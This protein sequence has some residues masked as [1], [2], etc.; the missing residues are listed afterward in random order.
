MD[1]L[2]QDGIIFTL[3]MPQGEHRLEKIVQEHI[4]DIFGNDA[5]S[6]GKKKIKSLA[7]IGSI[8][9][10]YVITFT[11]YPSWYVLEVE[12][13]RHSPYEHIIPQVTKFMNGIKNYQTQISLIKFFREEIAKDQILE[14]KIK[15]KIGNNEIRSF[16]TDLIRE[17]PTVAIVIENK[18]KELLEAVGELRATYKIVEFKTYEKKNVGMR[19][20]IHLFEPLYE[21]SLG[22]SKPVIVDKETIEVIG[23][24]RKETFHG[25]F[26][27]K[28]KEIIINDKRYS[29]SGA[30]KRMSGYNID[31]WRFWK[32]R[33]PG[34]G[35]LLPIDTYRIGISRVRLQKVTAREFEYKGNG[36][37]VLK[38]D[39]DVK[40]DANKSTK[41]V[42]AALEK[43]GY[44]VT[45][46][47]S[48]YHQLRKKA[49]LLRQRR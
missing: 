22:I 33:N 29:P 19:C 42:T 5:I 10:G 36:I 26:D 49:G 43:R 8:P 37:F 32:F 18:T 12:L 31:G 34:T 2:L 17:P 23:S 47:S 13:S 44:S 24:T 15:Q 6:F 30:A 11:P 20:H 46:P 4:T 35:E 45:R 28:T 48:F 41:E 1:I 21:L 27:P 16:L 14:N 3:W 7:G 25:L 9:D 40:I 39:S 38:K